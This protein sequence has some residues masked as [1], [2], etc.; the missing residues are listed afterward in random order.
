MRL[1]FP[2]LCRAALMAALMAATPL[3]VPAQVPSSAG[4]PAMVA[5]MASDAAV[6]T[7]VITYKDGETTLEGFLARPA[8]APAGAKLPAVMIVH[9]WKG[10]SDHE[11]DAAR[12][13]AAM[14]YIAF[15]ADIYGQGVR[16]QSSKDA[17]AEAG[18]YRGDRA[19]YR[20]RLLAGVETVRQ[21][22]GVDPTR[23]AAIGYCFGGTGMLELAR[24]G[25][26]LRGVVSFH[27]G[28]DSPTPADGANIKAKVLILHGASDALV[29][30]EDI[31]AVQKELT[32][33]K[34]DWQMVYYG[35]QV[36]SFTD[37][38]ATDPASAAMVRFDAVTERRSWEAMSDFLA[39]VLK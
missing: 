8:N 29:K 25:I 4:G 7:E 30:P 9:Q 32:D 17:G 10:L 39:E 19:L 38:G 37:K 13:L 34:V 11:R 12:R 14:G 36:H 3:P 20:R 16:P 31:A 21:I 18:K 26:D 5:T 22:P 24:T 28:I 6:A 23:V 33:N 15:A 27:G 1:P 35:N 2:I